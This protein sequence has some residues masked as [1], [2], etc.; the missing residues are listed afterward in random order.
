MPATR[1][2]LVC[3]CSE[4]GSNGQGYRGSHQLGPLRVVDGPPFACITQER[5]ANSTRLECPALNPQH[6]YHLFSACLWSRSCLLEYY[7]H[8]RPSHRLVTSSNSHYKRPTVKTTARPG[9]P[10]VAQQH[11][12]RPAARAA[13]LGRAVAVVAATVP[14]SPIMAACSRVS[15]ETSPKLRSSVK[16]VRTCMLAALLP[17]SGRYTAQR[18]PSSSR[19]AADLCPAG[20]ARPP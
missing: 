5:K 2:F 14:F 19:H 6:T 12:C 18:L 1:I 10:A 15:N 8:H 17:S 4:R 3:W 9:S 13:F 16:Y 7:A 11:A 20:P